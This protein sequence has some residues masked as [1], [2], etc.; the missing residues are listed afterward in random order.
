M[1]TNHHNKIGVTVD[2]TLCHRVL[3]ALPYP[4][5][6]ILSKAQ[7]YVARNFPSKGEVLCLLP[8]SCSLL[9]LNFVALFLICSLSFYTTSE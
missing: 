1:R 5:I 6:M 9:S 4:T 7:D 3:R 2:V 8:P